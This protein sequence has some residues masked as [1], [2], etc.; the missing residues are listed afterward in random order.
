M[1]P[2]VQCSFRILG[3]S[4]LPAS[5]DHDVDLIIGEELFL[6]VVVLDIRV[7]DRAMGAFLR[8]FWVLWGL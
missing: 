4:V 1:L 2:S 6:L 5:N 8:R 3:M 7:V